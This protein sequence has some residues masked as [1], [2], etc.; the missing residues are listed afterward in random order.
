[1]V[2]FAHLQWCALTMA[3]DFLTPYTRYVALC[4]IRRHV[5]KYK[6]TYVRFIPVNY[7]YATT[8][9]PNEEYVFQHQRTQRKCYLR[10]DS[11]GLRSRP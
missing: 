8:H 6:R 9:P 3:I 7:H 1:M 11:T 2:N 10:H 5:E 4:A